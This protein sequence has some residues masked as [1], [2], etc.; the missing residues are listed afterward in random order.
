MS[1]RVFEIGVLMACI[2]EQCF[3]DYVAKRHVAQ[4]ALSGVFN[5]DISSS[6]LHSP[7]Y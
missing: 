6:N 2:D 1:S 3:N 7:N 4:P 5:E